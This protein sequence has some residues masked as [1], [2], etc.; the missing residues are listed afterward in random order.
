[1][2]KI[3]FVLLLVSIFSNLSFANS[4]C[5]PGTDI[6]GNRVLDCSMSSGG[7]YREQ[8]KD[9]GMFRNDYGNE[10]FKT[11][12]QIKSENYLNF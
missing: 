10:D 12:E 9:S 8:E 6:Y 2:R 3:L 7:F 4:N 11:E 5:V 1:L